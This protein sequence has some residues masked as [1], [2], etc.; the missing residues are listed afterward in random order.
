MAEAI[1]VLSLTCV[2][3][4]YIHLQFDLFTVKESAVTWGRTVGASFII[5]G[6]VAFAILIAMG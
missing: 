3:V 5:R 1:L 4:S 2:L 6:V